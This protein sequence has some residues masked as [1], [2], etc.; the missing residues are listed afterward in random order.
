MIHL[1][2][3]KFNPKVFYAR[4]MM[5]ND[6][7]KQFDKILHLD[8]DIYIIR[9]LDYIFENEDFFIVSEVYE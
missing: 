9:P 5:W 3:Q 2:K 8:V 6:Y 4:F 1:D 7:F